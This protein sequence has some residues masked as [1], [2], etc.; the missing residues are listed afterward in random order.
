MTFFAT[1]Y[2]KN[3]EQ[4]STLDIFIDYFQ[5]LKLIVGPGAENPK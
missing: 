1:G 3:R 2:G 5:V 4:T